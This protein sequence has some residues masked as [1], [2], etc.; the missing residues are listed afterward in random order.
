MNRNM[1]L[2]I[3]VVVVVVASVGA[4][5]LLLPPVTTIA[6]P[7][8][9]TVIEETI[10]DPQHLDPAVDYETAGGAVMEQ[11][12]E[13][14]YW[15]PFNS[16]NTTPSQPMLATA[17]VISADG[18]NYT[19][20]LRQGVT[21]SD[22]I[23]FNA[24]CVKYSLE[25]LMKIYWGDGPAWMFGEPILGGQAV[26]DASNTYGG[27]SPQFKAAYDN[28]AANSSSIIVLDNYNV[29]FRLAY[30]YAP[31]FAVMAFSEASIISP[32][33]VEAHGGTGYGVINAYV[34]TH[35]CGTGPYTFVSWVP[36]EQLLLTLNT[37]YW[38]ATS[39]KTTYPHAGSITDIVY[40]YNVDVN[41]RIL[42]MLSN[43]TD[44]GAWPTT[45]ALY[46]WN[47]VNGSSGDGTLKSFYST[48]KLWCGEPTY[49]VNFIGMNE[50][51]YLNISNT[52]VKSPFVLK[53]FREA[54][55]YSFDY[56]TYIANVLHGFGKQAQGPIPYG[57]FGHNNSL[58][59]YSY[60]LDKAVLAWNDAMAHG[61]NDILTNMSFNLII[62]YN[63]GNTGRQQGSLLMADGLNKVLAD[64]LATKPNHTLTITAEGVAWPSYL[65]MLN[66]RQLA[67]FLLGWAPDFA[68][69]DDY[70]GPFVSS[71]GTYGSRIGLS[72]SAT[73]NA[74][75]VDGWIKAAAQELN[76]TARIADYG[77]IQQAISD[78]AAYIWTVQPTNFH[79]ECVYMNGYYYNPMVFGNYYYLY[80]KAY[81][82]GWTMPA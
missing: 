33:W 54:C 45:H 41:S 50:R 53:G 70:V 79:A 68:D 57:M 64:P 23:P 35:M 51:P 38:G 11:T 48:M 55:A 44:T 13:T 67:F 66:N 7:R 65:Y 82:A 26:E 81:P 32:S 3:I 39:I 77:K 47:Q 43:A 1:I 24:S 36:A 28:W 40:K 9:H 20:T 58:S 69:P 42:N 60:D 12:Y 16:D 62:Y 49:V 22:G 71:T 6:P 52:I 8:A 15:Y 78:E 5:I 74:T 80:Y 17:C 18:L 29:R 63:T 19:F 14:L 4:F 25:R 61:L 73:W 37:N 21:F 46:I 31:F 34:D 27:T 59:M 2:A 10:A 76:P 56:S 72:Y 75:L 30:K